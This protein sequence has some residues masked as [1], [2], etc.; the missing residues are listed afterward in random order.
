MYVVGTNRLN[1]AN[2]SRHRF[3]KSFNVKMWFGP[4][5]FTMLMNAREGWRLH[6]NFLFTWLDT[7]RAN[8]Q[9][10]QLTMWTEK[11]QAQCLNH[12]S[13]FNGFISHI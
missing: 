7:G 3:L 1:N 13:I 9:G 10:R 2:V 4:A 12:F 11:H 6:F 8:S 5:F